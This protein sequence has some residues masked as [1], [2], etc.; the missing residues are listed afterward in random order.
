MRSSSTQ[1]WASNRP[2]S[3][4]APIFS[5]AAK[6]WRRKSDHKTRDC[7]RQFVLKKRFRAA[8]ACNCKIR[9]ANIPEKRSFE[10]S[11]R[12]ET[13][14]CQR[15]NPNTR[16]PIQAPVNPSAAE[17]ATA[18]SARP[19]PLP[20]TKSQAS[21]CVLAGRPIAYFDQP[22]TSHFFQQRKQ[23]FFAANFV[24]FVFVEDRVAYL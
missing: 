15:L 24:D 16:K 7:S 23:I 6:P 2:A 10:L 1:A 22:F 3:F 12:P 13:N 11:I 19:N 9:F 18:R 14:S 20:H 17:S 4:R 21:D 8:A 5:S